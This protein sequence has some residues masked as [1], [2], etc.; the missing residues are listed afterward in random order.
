MDA[1]VVVA[2]HS[3][4]ASQAWLAAVVALV[5]EDGIFVLPAVVVAVWV[6]AR[7]A[8]GRREAIIAGCVAA[9]LAAALGL[10]LERTLA[11]PRPFV[12][13]GFAPLFAHVPDSSFPSDHTLVGVALV[14]ALLWGARRIGVW[15]VGAALLVGCA[16]IAVGL[17]YPSDIL[18][19]AVLA[20]V[21]DGLAWLL[22]LRL[23]PM[24]PASLRAGL[25]PRS[26]TLP[27]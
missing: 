21:I 15:L 7:P 19:S 5:A 2:L 16:R 14:G 12:E 25:R 17:H 24:F 6:T 9:V 4:V 27:G 26:P 1:A 11:R 13:L 3:W 23:L 22:L 18:G 10:Y 20:L 8:D